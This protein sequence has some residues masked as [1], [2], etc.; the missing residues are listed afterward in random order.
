MSHCI[1]HLPGDIMSQ[2]MHPPPRHFVP[3]SQFESP[4]PWAKLVRV[5]GISCIYLGLFLAIS[6]EHIYLYS[7][8]L[9]FSV[10]ALEVPELG[11]RKRP[12]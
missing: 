1:R 6:P 4:I 12:F 11:V 2:L 7:Q 5:S 9:R 3:L 10:R 8:I